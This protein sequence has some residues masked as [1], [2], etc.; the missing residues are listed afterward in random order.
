[1]SDASNDQPQ[2]ENPS[3][4][5]HAGWL[6]KRAKVLALFSIVALLGVGLLAGLASGHSMSRIEKLLDLEELELTDEQSDRIMG[7][8]TETRKETIQLRSAFKIARIE[9]GELLTQDAVDNEAIAQKADQIGQSAQQLVQLWTAAAI[10]VRDLLTPEQV[11]TARPYLMKFLSH[12]RGGH[13][14]RRWGR[15]GDH[16]ER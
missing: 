15:T 16:E 9:M 7:I 8:M 1:M 12:G 4:R 6:R 13:G 3:T 14:H 10:D 11:K 2:A 5:T